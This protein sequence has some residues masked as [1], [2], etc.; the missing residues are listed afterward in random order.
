ML[1]MVGGGFGY[2]VNLDHETMNGHNGF[3]VYDKKNEPVGSSVAGLGDINDDGYTDFAISETFFQRGSPPARVYIFFGQGGKSFPK[4]INVN[5]GAWL[6][7]TT[8]M[9]IVAPNDDFDHIAGVRPV[10]DMNGDGVDDFAVDTPEG[11]DRDDPS[12]V[13]VVFGSRH[14]PAMIEDLRNY[15]NGTNGFFAP[16]KKSGYTLGYRSV[17]HAGDFNGDGMDDMIL[18]C[19]CGENYIIYGSRRPFNTTVDVYALDGENGVLLFNSKHP[20]YVRGIPNAVAGGVDFNGDGVDD[21]FV[22]NYYTG[23]VSVLYGGNT[24]RPSPVDLG[25]LNGYDGT[26]FTMNCRQ[27]FCMGY[28]LGAL[29]DFNGDGFGDLVIGTRSVGDEQ[30]GGEV[31]LVMGAPTNHY[32]ATANI[33]DLLD[34]VNATSLVAPFDWDHDSGLGDTV[35]TAGDFNND[36]YTDAFMAKYNYGAPWMH[37]PDLLYLVFGGPTL[38]TPN[39]TITDIASSSHGIQFK[40]NDKHTHAMASQPADVNNDGVDD[41]IFG[42]PTTYVFY[43][44]YKP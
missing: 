18:G 37:S 31:F 22:G 25:I 42:Y 19:D 36:G 27:Y 38:L 29:E 6:D 24:E 21:I 2:V 20:S 28:A 5:R 41:I 44:P 39:Y 23:V 10:G 15:V 40:S 17:Y 3:K 32:P 43:G 7:G 33:Y 9:T 16:V 34:G 12:G 11:Y 35:A 13:Y 1:V 14:L 8:G 30:T 4:S 26:T